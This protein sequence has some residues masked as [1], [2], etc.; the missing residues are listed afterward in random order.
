MIPTLIVFS[1]IGFLVIWAILNTKESKKGN[2]KKNFAQLIGI[3]AGFVVLIGLFGMVS[4]FATKGID[5]HSEEIIP[6]LEK[7]NKEI[8]RIE[9]VAEKS[10]VG[11][12]LS[13]DHKGKE[14][15][16]FST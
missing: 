4:K 14:M 16:S 5:Y 9:V 11:R 15:E 8:E 12:F 7:N 1:L 2:K 3:I 6:I 13:G 10:K